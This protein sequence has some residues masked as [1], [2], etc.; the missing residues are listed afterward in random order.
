MT[1]AAG[2]GHHRLRAEQ[3]DPHHRAEADLVDRG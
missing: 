3:H 2:D 1:P